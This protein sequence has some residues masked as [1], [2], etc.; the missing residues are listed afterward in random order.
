MLGV[1]KK[2]VVD[3]PS[4][5]Y[6]VL[7]GREQFYQVFFFFVKGQITSALNLLFVLITKKP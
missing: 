5:F 1:G 2:T 7:F 6:F 4:F 3:T